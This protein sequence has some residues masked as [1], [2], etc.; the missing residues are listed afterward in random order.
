MV[1][2]VRHVALDHNKFNLVE[3]RGH[4]HMLSSV[5]WLMM[6]FRIRTFWRSRR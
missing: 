5:W 3:V 1:H 2:N 6:G 4:Q